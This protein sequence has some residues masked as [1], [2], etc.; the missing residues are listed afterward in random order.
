[1]IVLITGG[2]GS[3][4]SKIAENI[5]CRL[6][7][8]PLYYLATM[9]AQDAECRRRI[10]QHRKQ[11]EGKGFKTIEVPVCLKENAEMLTENASV[12]LECM[13]NLLANE[14]FGNAVQDP[15]ETILNGVSVLLRRMHHVT[16]V[17]NEIFSDGIP[18]DKQIQHYLQYLG[19]IN[20]TIA[21]CADIVMESYAGIP[22]FWK[23]EK[24]YH[25]IMD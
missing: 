13:S 25:E 23:G 7:G 5:I 22:I 24:W 11:R 6:G 18:Q 19:R 20:C 12:L 1:M 21:A 14:Q 4:K 15:V 10:L 9:Q 2:A 16:I 17:T 8:R 3:G